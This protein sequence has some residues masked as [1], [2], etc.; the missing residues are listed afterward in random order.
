MNDNQIV[1]DL[2]D[3]VV[4]KELIEHSAQRGYIHPKSFNAVGTVYTKIE[5]VLNAAA[6]R[7]DSQ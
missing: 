7:K 1:I 3:L 4:I 5:T 2:Q 6:A